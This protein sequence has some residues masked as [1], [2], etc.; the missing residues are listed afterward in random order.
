MT[1]QIISYKSTD[2]LMASHAQ[3]KRSAL[4]KVWFTTMSDD[5][6]EVTVE[7]ANSGSTL[8]KLG[9][10]VISLQQLKDMPHDAYDSMVFNDA[11]FELM[12]LSR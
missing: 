4:V 1:K 8:K 11:A 6:V 9:K 2:G 3:L 10:K 5:T 7:S 12:M